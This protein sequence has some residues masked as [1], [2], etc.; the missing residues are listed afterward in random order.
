[1]IFHWLALRA[2]KEIAMWSVYT[3]RGAIG[4]A[5]VGAIAPFLFAPAAEPAKIERHY[6]TGKVVPLAAPLE[7]FG[8]RLDPDA[9]PSWYALVSD[10]GKQVYPL[11]KDDGAR[12]FFKDK[13]LLNR[14]MRIT[15]RL[16]PGS[17]L[18]QALEVHSLV[19]GKLHELYYWCEVCQIKRYEKKVCDCCGAPLELRETP[20]RE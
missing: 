12:M 14:P 5:L 3:R 17:H 4:L 7:K 10:D 2:Q 19:Q 6:Y 20:L 13:R 18:L 8:A 11:I 15:G 16:Y 9:A 1:M